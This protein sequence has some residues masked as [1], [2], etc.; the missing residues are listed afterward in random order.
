MKNVCEETLAL[1]GVRSD[2]RQYAEM[3]LDLN[4]FPLPN[5]KLYKEYTPAAVSGKIYDQA[6][7]LRD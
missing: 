1:P 5:G 3:C 6:D 2:Y 4:G 7:D